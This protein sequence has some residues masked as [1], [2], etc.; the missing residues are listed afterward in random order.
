MSLLICSVGFGQDFIGKKKIADRYFN[1]FDFYKAVPMYEQLLKSTPNDAGLYLKLATI[2]DHLNDSQGAERCYA[3]LV[4]R[5]EV[6]PEYLLDYARSLSR[7]GKYDKALIYYRKYKEVSP[8]DPRGDA[9]SQAYQDMAP[10][11][12]DSASF[13][14]KK[15][16]FSSLSDEFSPAYFGKTIVF[17]SD[18]SGFSMI[19][20]KYN[21]TQSSYLDLYQATPDSKEAT[22][23]SKELNSVYHE[24]PVTFSRNRDTI[25]FT[26]SN[27]F[28]SHLRKS[29]EGI[30]KLSLFGANWDKKQN[31]WV[32]IHPLTLNNDEY[33]DQH[34]AISPDG[35]QLYYASD[36]KGGYGGMDLYVSQK[37]NNPD[38]TS[39]WGIPVNLGPGI[40]SPGIEAF[41]FADEQGNLWYA[42]DGIPGLGGLDIFFA[43]KTALGFAKTINPGFPMNTRFDDFGYITD[44]TGE[45]GYFSSN[46]NN[47]YADDDIYS[48]SRTFPKKLLRVYDVKTSK[49]LPLAHLYIIEYGA[50]PK[51]V[52]TDLTGTIALV[53]NPYKSYGFKAVSD[54]Y[55]PGSLELTQEQLSPMDTIKIALER[56]PELLPPVAE[57][58]VGA[59]ITLQDI[60]YD[61]NKSNIRPDAAL[62]LDK[63][64]KILTDHPKMM[65]ELRSHTDSRASAA[66]NLKLSD[67]RAKSAAAYLFSKGIA[68]DRIIGKGYGESML[69]NKCA[70]GV[71]CSEEEHQK[72]RRTEFKIL[73]ME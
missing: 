17:S 12:K 49:D 39:S 1:R 46:R 13:K 10:F 18:R 15:A 34:P 32:N 25:I 48:I 43:A 8:Q 14:I 45:A 57:Y 23:F 40:N 9:F 28:E 19:R 41:P 35:K 4:N 2:Y 69:L 65:I 29:N 16:P 53:F 71:Q 3:F 37:I 6:K 51:M 68:K 64:F 54:K 60:L 44:G 72:N 7:N 73:R 22:S 21:W 58:R 55:K 52:S 67:Q 11:Y 63:L 36:M 31:K 26:R 56:E 70:D 50:E 66:Y 59:I 33:S 20:S 24:G 42:S 47:G 38:G 62:V 27:Y 30:N 5:K 61:L